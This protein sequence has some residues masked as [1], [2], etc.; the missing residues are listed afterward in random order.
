MPSDEQDQSELLD[1]DKLPGE[2]PPDEPMGVDTYGTTAAEERAGEPITEAIARENT[3]YS[4][5]GAGEP[6]PPVDV[7]VSRDRTT[8]SATLRRNAKA[9]SRRKKP[10]CTSNRG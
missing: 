7:V 2:Y 9:P 10:H 8:M 4:D 3:D 1:D 6:V 5:R